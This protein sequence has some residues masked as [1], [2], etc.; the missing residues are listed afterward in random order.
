[1]KRILGILTV[2]A[3][4]ACGASRAQT[5]KSKEIEAIL[6]ELESLSEQR[7]KLVGSERENALK[8]VRA[9]AASEASAAA[10]YEE[11]IRVTQFAGVKREGGEF[12][13]WKKRSSDQLGSP[14]MRRAIQ[15]HLNYLALSLERA[16]GKEIPELLPGLLAH[17]KGLTDSA[18]LF[19]EMDQSVK[20]AVNEMLS[21]SVAAGVFAEGMGLGPALSGLKDWEM[22]PGN[23]NGIYTTTIL[24]ELR[25]VK[26]PRLIQYW[27][28]RINIESARAADDTRDFEAAKFEGIRKPQ[29]V[30]SRAEDMLLL[31]QTVPA[32]TEMLRV[33]KAYPAHPQAGAW[34]AKLRDILKKLTQPGPVATPWVEPAPA[35]TPATDPS[36]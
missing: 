19:D 15:F 13:E 1:M 4:L 10:F 14:A 8:K 25:R 5:I 9:A 35:E 17:A 34:I 11:A 3:C 12:R 31:G 23:A 27:D 18:D 33:I 29:L 20:G 2:I 24:P 32:L 22:S 7:I 26:D 30:W 16:M 21:K 36:A 6:R 28:A